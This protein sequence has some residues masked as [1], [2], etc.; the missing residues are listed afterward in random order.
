MKKITSNCEKTKRGDGFMQAAMYTRMG[1]Q[2]NQVEK[3]IGYLRLSKDDGDDI[4]SMSISNQR[5]MIAE[6]AEHNNFIIEEWYVDDGISGYTMS[7]P[8]FNRLKKDLNNNK[9]HTIIAKDFSRIG[10][11]NAK[12]QLFLENI[13]ED[14][15]RVLTITE[16]YDTLDPRTHSYVGIHGWVNENFIRETSTKVRN[17]ITILQKEG[18]WLCSIPYGY[19][20]DPRDKYKYEIDPTT[21]PYVKQIFDMYI[22]GMGVKLIAKKL[23]EMNVPT[24]SMVKKINKEARGEVCRRKA[25]TTWGEVAIVRILRNEFYTG[26]L[27]LG[28]SKRRSING[29][30]IPQPEESRHVFKDVH[31]PIIDKH[32]FNL[33]QSITVERAESDYRGKKV[34]TRPNIF[35]GLLYCADCGKTLTSNSGRANNTRYI[36]RTYNVAGVSH[37]TSHA[38]SERD[39]RFALLDFLSYCRTNLTNI[40]E[41]LDSIIRAE[42]QVKGK[43]ENGIEIIV[44]KLQNTKK[45][46]EVLIEQKMRETMKNPTM[47][48]MI[49]KMYD[50]MLNE[51]YKEVQILEKQLND[52]QQ[53]N[54]DEVE[55][56]N[57]LN[58]ALSIINDILATKN[59]TKKQVL[60]LVDKIV[61]HEDTGV[62]IYLKG[63]LHKICN[64][65]FV[66]KGGTKNQIKKL[67]CDFILEHPKKFTTNECEVYV[68]DN[69]IR[70]S[71]KKISK[72]IKEDLLANDLIK[73]RPMNHGY[74]LI[75]DP[76]DLKA[77]LI[78]NIVG[79]ISGSLRYN[80]VIINV[81]KSICQWLENINS[82]NSKKNL[83]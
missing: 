4:E 66:V 65:Y 45:S 54:L 82:K 39:I 57:G 79:N 47:I 19:I 80:S 59:I 21:A 38:V 24:P 23:T 29:K 5:K 44:E 78:P 61:V 43:S 11:H 58:N 67:V 73:I 69:G 31:E 41:D 35:A 52:Q 51:K 15:K 34:Q 10:R 26:T 6:Y 64:N 50:E 72:I 2:G 27:V 40:I 12:V 25:S 42:I 48:D 1:K 20:K 13:L 68:R 71:Y 46:I 17:S 30:S 60:M 3:A 22:E 32:T 70:I 37:C 53:L 77:Q 18:K 9:V 8:D 14:G 81:A 49:D 76:E 7:R 36:C 16:G 56:K 75:A 28:K 83:F 74:E 55:I 33:V 62:D 63:D